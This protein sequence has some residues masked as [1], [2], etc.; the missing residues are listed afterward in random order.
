MT[1]QEAEKLSFSEYG[2]IVAKKRGVS[3]GLVFQRVNDWY[4]IT[5]TEDEIH[6]VSALWE[7]DEIEKIFQ[8]E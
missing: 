4:S 3:F 1:L 5:S 6:I 2:N 8:V 7:L